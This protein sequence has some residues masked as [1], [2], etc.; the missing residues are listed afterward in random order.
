MVYSQSGQYEAIRNEALIKAAMWMNLKSL[1]PVK[2]AMLFKLV[3]KTCPEHRFTQQS[4]RGSQGLE[5]G[6]GSDCS[7][8]QGL[9]WGEGS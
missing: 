7:R 8:A 9:L 6:V 1:C 2:E 3:Y 4:H 5:E